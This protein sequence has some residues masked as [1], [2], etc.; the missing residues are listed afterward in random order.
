MIPF[1]IDP[2]PIIA[3]SFGPSRDRLY[4]ESIGGRS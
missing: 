2:P 1:T 3:I 4:E